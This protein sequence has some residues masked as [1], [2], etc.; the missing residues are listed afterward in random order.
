MG[1]FSS[2]GPVFLKEASDAVAFIEKMQELSEQAMGDCKKEIDKQIKIA[3]YGLA[4]EET[5]AFE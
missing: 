5:I 1:L 4:G 2:C 3:S